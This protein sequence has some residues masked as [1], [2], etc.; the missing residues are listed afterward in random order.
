MSNVLAQSLRRARAIV[1]VAVGSRFEYYNV[2]AADLSEARKHG[3][4]EASLDFPGEPLA[5]SEKDV[6]WVS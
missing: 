1:P 6:R 2:P 3:L 4:T 5:V